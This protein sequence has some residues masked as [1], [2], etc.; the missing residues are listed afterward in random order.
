[1]SR[2]LLLFIITVVSLQGC[3]TLSP[4][5]CQTMDGYTVGLQ[6]GLQ[7]RTARPVEDFHKACAKPHDVT[8]QIAEYGRGRG[9]GLKQFC[10]ARIG[11]QLGSKG[12]HYNGVCPGDAQQEFLAAYRQGKEIFDSEL[13]IRRLA[14]ILHVNRSQLRTLTATA[15]RKEAEM[16]AHDTASKRRAVLL[17]EMSDLQ[18]TVAMVETEI[19]GIEAALEE[20]NRHLQNLTESA[21]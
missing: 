16:A 7:G 13:Q 19:S 5:E 9:Q 14:E 8:A 12:V 4:D 11:F 10:S 6:D 3:G 1:M 21:R 20:E 2:I 15:Q 18:Q 17:A